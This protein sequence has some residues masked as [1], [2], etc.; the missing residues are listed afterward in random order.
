MADAKFDVS[1][2]AFQDEFAELTEP[3]SSS[4]DLTVFSAKCEK[5]GF[6]V[7]ALMVDRIILQEIVSDAVLTEFAVLDYRFDAFSS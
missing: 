4:N 7:R 5:C 3:R 6:G 2:S 1:D